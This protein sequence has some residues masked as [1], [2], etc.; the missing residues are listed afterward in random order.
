MPK[1]ETEAVD[2]ILF[3]MFDEEEEAEDIDDSV[4]S[5]AD[6]DETVVNF[7]LDYTD[8]LTPLVPNAPKVPKKKEE[9]EEKKEEVKATA[10]TETKANE[11]KPLEPNQDFLNQLVLMG[12]NVEFSKKALI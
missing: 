8:S 11:N 2:D 10:A 5:E 4:Q 9:E 7:L 1:T 12:F 3:T 6:Q